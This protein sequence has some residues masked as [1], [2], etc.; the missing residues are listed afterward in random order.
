MIL[1]RVKPSE[2]HD[3]ITLMQAAAA[4]LDMPGVEDAAVIMGTPANHEIAAG[5]AC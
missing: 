1:T 4:L 5:A 3:S 2:Y